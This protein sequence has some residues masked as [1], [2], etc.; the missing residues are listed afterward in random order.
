[1]LRSTG[2]PT[3]L[4]SLVA[5]TVAAGAVALATDPGSAGALLADVAAQ[6]GSA[7]LGAIEGYVGASELSTI[8]AVAGSV[9]V[10][11]AVGL[12]GHVVRELDPNVPPPSADLF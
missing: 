10:L 3:K 6:F 5:L 9:Y 4:L 7:L 2:L 8:D 1:M 11:V 12:L